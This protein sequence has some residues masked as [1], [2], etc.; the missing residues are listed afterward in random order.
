M[1]YVVAADIGG[2]RTKLGLVE[3]ENERVIKSSVISTEGNSKE[4]FLSSFEKHMNGLIR[5][6]GVKKTEI[7]GLGVSIGSYIFPHSGIVDTM[8]GFINIPDRYPCKDLFEDMF[9]LPCRIEND[10]RLIA[11]AE[12]LYGVGRKN[13]RVL[14]LTLGTGVGIG[15]TVGK[16]FQDEDACMHL[17]GHIKVRFP[18]QEPELDKYPCY[19]NVSGCL[20]STC[21][22]TALMRLTR[23]YLGEDADNVKLFAEAKAGKIEAVSIVRRYISYLAAALNQYV[24]IYAPDMIVLGGGVAKG[25]SPWLDELRSLVTASIHSEYKLEIVTSTLSEEAGILG[26]ASLFL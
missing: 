11:Y 26:A 16:K 7:V 3:L 6:S 17:A 19:C 14:T 9:K 10:A 13:N 4:A 23:K 8:D 18:G 2:T 1:K 15:M 20:E 22:G 25:L 21:S 5:E 24:Y 12:S